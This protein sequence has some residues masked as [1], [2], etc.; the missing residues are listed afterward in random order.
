ML[1]RSHTSVREGNL[2]LGDGVVLFQAQR[3]RRMLPLLDLL[4]QAL[5]DD[6]QDSALRPCDY[7]ERARLPV[8]DALQHPS[9]HGRCRTR[10]EGEQADYWNGTVTSLITSKDN[11]Y[12]IWI[13]CVTPTQNQVLTRPHWPDWLSQAHCGH[14]I[15]NF[16]A[17]LSFNVLY[18]RLK[19]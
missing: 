11:L 8:T 19:Q 14:R 15:I 3:R 12:F 18:L 2:S 4:I 17:S 16:L 5:M 10:L 1:R 7:W 13:S 6:E 9:N